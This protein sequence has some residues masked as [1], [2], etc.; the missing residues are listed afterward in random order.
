MHPE[1]TTLSSSSP[2][3]PLLLPLACRPPQRCLP[4]APGGRNG[5][6]WHRRAAAKLSASP[7]FPATPREA[8]HPLN[9]AL[10]SGVRM[11]PPYPCP[12]PPALGP[13]TAPPL[14]GWGGVRFGSRGRCSPSLLLPFRHGVE[15][16][17]RGCF[18]PRVPPEPNLLPQPF[19]GGGHRWQRGAA[20]PGVWVRQQGKE[21]TNSPRVPV[22]GVVKALQTLFGG[23]KGG[24]SSALRLPAF[25]PRGW[26]CKTR[27]PPASS[28]VAAQPGGLGRSGGPACGPVRWGQGHREQEGG[29]GR[30][31][32]RAGLR[33]QQ[34]GGGKAPLV[35]AVPALLSAR[36]RDPGYLK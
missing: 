22:S 29:P 26:P 18:Q 8:E 23:V 3:A 15:G 13:A 19:P 16:G 21:G 32:L 2:Q 28:H 9:P 24:T 30:A 35:A 5:G 36:G 17:A 11:R 4:G 25:S 27:P 1:G 10:T 33:Q 14:P 6:S 12:R 20:P 7:P 31:G 34:L